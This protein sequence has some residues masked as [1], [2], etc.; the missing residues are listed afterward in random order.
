MMKKVLMNALKTGQR[1]MSIYFVIVNEFSKFRSKLV[2]YLLFCF[3]FIVGLFFWAAGR[4]P[5]VFWRTMARDTFYEW[6]LKK[7]LIGKKRNFCFLFFAQVTWIFFNS[8]YRWF[9]A[10]CKGIACKYV[11]MFFHKKKKIINGTRHIVSTPCDLYIRRK[12][13][14]KK[15]W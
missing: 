9:S 15:T 14:K 12:K 4:E 13:S 8:P 3:F 2:K 7:K 10:M 6:R 11:S 5:G 1:F